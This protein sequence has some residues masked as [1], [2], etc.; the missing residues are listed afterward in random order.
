M[1]IIKNVFVNG[2]S[3]VSK[4]EKPAVKQAENGFALFKTKSNN[5]F[6]SSQEWQKIFEEI[7][8]NFLKSD[9]KKIKNNLQKK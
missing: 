5:W 3:L 4:K 1:R 2:I 6:L 8:K 7:K 9:I